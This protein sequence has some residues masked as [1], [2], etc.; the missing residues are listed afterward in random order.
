MFKNSTFCYFI[1]LFVFFQQDQCADHCS[2]KSDGYIESFS[3]G[4]FLKNI[5]KKPDEKLCSDGRCKHSVFL[6]ALGRAISVTAIVALLY[7]L[8]HSIKDLQQFSLKSFTNNCLAFVAK[9]NRPVN[10]SGALLFSYWLKPDQEKKEGYDDK[11]HLRISNKELILKLLCCVPLLA[12]L[13]KDLIDKLAKELPS[14]EMD[15]AGFLGEIVQGYSLFS[16]IKT[17]AG[18]VGGDG[19]NYFVVSESANAETIHHKGIYE[20]FGKSVFSGDDKKGP[21]L[22]RFTFFSMISGFFAWGL[23]KYKNKKAFAVAL[24]AGLFGAG[25]TGTNSNCNRCLLFGNLF[26]SLL[27]FSGNDA[28][29]FALFSKQD[30]L[31]SSLIS[32]L[33]SGWTFM[34]AEKGVTKKDAPVLS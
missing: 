9:E 27:P 34:N 2:L 6:P 7:G 13:S 24:K 5:F 21:Y 8:K 23:L 1:V 31:A 25:I 16:F 32:L 18:A 12:T 3:N 11:E 26:S 10:L 14:G 30:A 19:T 22:K 4:L 28:G 33:S 29:L 17:L 15:V 20:N